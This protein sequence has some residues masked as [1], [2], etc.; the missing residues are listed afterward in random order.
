MVAIQGYVRSSG[1]VFLQNYEKILTNFRDSSSIDP[2]FSLP[3]ILKILCSKSD[4]SSKY[5][6]QSLGVS[7]INYWSYVYD[8]LHFL[9]SKEIFQYLMFNLIDIQFQRDIQFI[10]SKACCKFAVSWHLH[11][12]PKQHKFKKHM[13]YKNEIW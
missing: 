7:I 4:R 8:F 13:N 3:W 10:I 6:S 12:K 1:I 5:E 11:S 9:V 2:K